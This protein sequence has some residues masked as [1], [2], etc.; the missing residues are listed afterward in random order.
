MSSSRS[1]QVLLRHLANLL[2]PGLVFLPSF[3]AF[4]QFQ[5]YPLWRPEVLIAAGFLLLV[6]L[7]FG[8]LLALR[9]RTFGAAAVTLLLLALATQIFAEG[10]IDVL[11][12]WGSLSQDLT[13]WIGPFGGIAVTVLIALP[14]AAIPFAALSWLGPNLGIVLA[15]V[16]SV[17]L[18]SSLLLPAEPPPLG[19]TYRRDAG[20]A[21]D[22]PPIIHL[23]FDEQIGVEGLPSDIADGADLRDEL[24]RFYADFGFT[25][26]GRAYSEYSQTP[27]S[28]ISLLNGFDSLDGKIPDGKY[29]R[30][31]MYW[32]NHW[33]KTLTERGYLIHAYHINGW[34]FCGGKAGHTTRCV[35][36]SDGSITNIEGT[37]LTVDAKVKVILVSYLHA[38][39]PYRIFRVLAGPA[40]LP[41]HMLPEQPNLHAPDSLAVLEQM[42]ADI[43]AA[44]RGTAYF[45]H[46]L[47]PHDTHMLDQDC[48]IRADPLTWTNSGDLDIPTGV[49]NSAA[50]RELRYIGYFAQVRCL[51][52]A[53]RRFFDGLMEIGAFDDATIVL[54]GDHG[55]RIARIA[56]L[57]TAPQ[58]LSDEDLADMYSVLYA[59]R[60]PSLAPGY[61]QDLRSL[62][63]LFRE[64]FLGGTPRDRP[65]EVYLDYPATIHTRL[66]KPPFP[67]RPMSD[68]GRAPDSP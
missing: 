9:P 43:R 2:A 4:V 21:K 64:M 11:G 40:G 66:T 5:G 47:I 27:H 56:P 18:V 48:K 51:H 61:R 24:R 44:P 28:M 32:D 39:V 12:S 59:V 15:T 36:Y 63:T 41:P 22:L 34:D 46:L 10:I 50:S 55:S 25:L 60:S 53:L 26:Y 6:G 14:I 65:P 57:T 8:L 62:Q 49:L 30:L 20:P 33:F 13:D 68:L 42:L 16:F 52:S 38:L 7:P 17:T 67:R 58:P 45:A 1:P 23:V 54:H 31:Q 29:E 3:A 37:D 19:E 35:T